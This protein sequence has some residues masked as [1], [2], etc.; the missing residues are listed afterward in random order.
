MFKL[1]VITDEVSQDLD[2]A[3]KFAKKYDL[4]SVELRSVAGKDPF[5]YTIEDV[6]RIKT[7]ADHYGIGI[8][9][10]AAP[11]FKCDFYHKSEVDSHFEGLKRCVEWANILGAKIIRGFDFWYDGKNRL[12]LDA[13][14][15]K[16]GIVSDI[17][18]GSDTKIAIEYDPSV[19]SVNCKEVSELVHYIG[20]DNIGVLFDPGNDIYSPRFEVPYP[21]G[22][23]FAK[24]AIFHIHIKDAVCKEGVVTAMPVGEGAV[25]Y[26]GLFGELRR[27]HYDGFISL[28]THYKPNLIIDDKVLKQPKGDAISYMGEEASS[29]CME[30]LINLINTCL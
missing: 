13:R 3:M 28:E 23:E 22:Y 14:A 19:N 26:K 20:R 7:I 1:S 2:V 30:N 9:S 24:E 10:I 21:D 25:D 11:L 4:D 12:S 27:I 8:C 16:Y 6:R 15:E 18:C 17:I 29:I 5:E